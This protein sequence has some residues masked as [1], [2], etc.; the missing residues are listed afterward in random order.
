MTAEPLTSPLNLKRNDIGKGYQSLAENLVK[1]DEL[2]K[3]ARTLQ[4]DRLN[5]GQGIEAAMIT[6]KVKWHN[7]FR[8]RYN[9]QI[10]QRAGKREHQSPE[11]GDAPYKCSRLQSL[12]KSGRELCFFCGE[13]GG[14]DGLHEVTTFQVDQHVCKCAKLTGDSFLLV[15]L[16][17]VDIGSLGN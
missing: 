8:L 5:E 16:S 14:T 11:I 15:K 1:F 17:L 7:T 12:L 3:L 10:L 13:E 9:N 6:N 4:L 2:G